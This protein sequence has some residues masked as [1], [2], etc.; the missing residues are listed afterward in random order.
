MACHPASSV[1]AS[2]WFH[3][4]LLTQEPRTLL[5]G[6][7]LHAPVLPL[8]L[9]CNNVGARQVESCGFSCISFES[10]SL[11]F[12][13]KTLCGIMSTGLGGQSMA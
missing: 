9:M 12:G 5:A 1:A 6:S 2:F 10:E 11:K 3:N 13:K 8:L 4:S 7:L